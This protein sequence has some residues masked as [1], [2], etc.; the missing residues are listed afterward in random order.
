MEWYDI[1]AKLERTEAD[2]LLLLDCC[3]SASAGRDSK[4]TNRIEMITATA[5]REIT[6]PPGLWSWTH[7]LMKLLEKAVAE[8]GYVSAELLARELLS[9]DVGLPATSNHVVLRSGFPSRSI[10]LRP[11]DQHKHKPSQINE[12]GPCIRL[13]IRVS[14]LDFHRVEQIAT[15]LRTDLPPNV[16]LEVDSIIKRTEV[17]QTLVKNMSAVE[18]PLHNALD[19]Q[20]MSEIVTVWNKIS[21]LIMEYQCKRQRYAGQKEFLELLENEARAFLRQLD[22]RNSVLVD[23]VEQGILQA[24]C[25]DD[26]SDLEHIMEIPEIKSS[27]IS[28]Q[29]H[30]R[31]MILDSNYHHADK[32][33][34]ALSEM[35]QQTQ[36]WYER[37]KYGPYLDPADLPQVQQRISLMADLLKASKSAEF[38]ALKCNRW[39]HNPAEDMF[40]LE[41]EGN[42]LGGF[43][44]LKHIV[45]T[46]RG[47]ARP[48]LGQRFNFALQIAQAVRKWHSVGWVHQS[49]NAYNVLFPKDRASG[50]NFSNIFLHGFDFARPS[51]G[52]SLGHYIDDVDNDVYRHPERQGLSRLGHTKIHDLYSLGVVLLEIGLWEDVRK[53]A[54]GS[55]K[56]GLELPICEMDLSLKS[57]TM[58]RLAHY[59]GKDYQEAVLTCLSSDF[60]VPL[61]DPERSILAKAFQQ[62]VVAKLQKAEILR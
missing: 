22:D 51:Q 45:L 49:I 60:G 11:L 55:V 28:N 8:N 23:S 53:T 1:Q 14:D 33:D 43:T 44:T 38:R 31:K 37:K 56:R 29:L 12:E 20:S 61:D 52:P 41:F 24:P 35:T 32:P 15:W 36:L 21:D 25:A 18:E 6:P 39:F 7:A 47:P 13:I 9:M 16:Y 19:L 26:Q 34:A 48:T 58:N 50:V 59:M 10:M 2:V 57:A 46:G 62:R 40:V 30:L 27:G 17:V 54:S 42:S 4:K 3:F 5:K